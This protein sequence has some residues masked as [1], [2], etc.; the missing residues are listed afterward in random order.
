MSFCVVGVLAVLGRLTHETCRKELHAAPRTLAG[1][2]A[3]DVRMHWAGVEDGSFRGT[4]VH[5]GDEGNRLVRWGVEPRLQLFTLRLPFGVVA[6]NV[7]R[8]RQRLGG[9]GADIDGR[10]R[11]HAIRGSMRERQLPGLL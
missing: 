5:L 9:F 4:Q 8:L 6:E 3:D 11:V 2:L 1:R 7:K 10:E